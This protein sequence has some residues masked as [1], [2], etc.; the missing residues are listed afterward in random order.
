MKHSITWISLLATLVIGHAV[1]AASANGPSA[2]GESQAV[3]PE[4]TPA[5]P[6]E[7]END[8][9]AGYLD[10]AYVY[11]SAE[12]TALAARLKDYGRETHMSLDD[13]VT[14]RLEPAETEGD[15][16]DEVLVRR[17]AIARLLQYL[18]SG[19]ADALEASVTAV[20]TLEGR[21]GRHENRYW[22]YYILAHRA[23]E[24]GHRFDFV[25]DVLSLWLG[26][27][28][29]LETPYE[30]LDTL[31]L[32]EAPNSGFAAALPY[33]YENVARLVLIRSQE[34]GLD[35]DIDPLSSIVRLLA[36]GRVGGHPEV[37]PVAAS[38]KEY[39]ARIIERLNGPESD[40]GGL[41]FTLALFEATKL[42]DQ[43]RGLLASEGLGPKTIEAM[44]LASGAYQTALDRADTVQGQC[45]VYRRVL[46]LDK[47]AS[48]RDTFYS[49]V[50]DLIAAYECGF[51]DALV[52]AFKTKG[53][54]L[55]SWEV[56]ALFHRFEVQAH[57]KP[58][59]EKARNKMASRDLAFRD[60]LHLQLQEYVTPL[61]RD[62]FER[63]LGEKS[64]ELAERLEEAKDV[65]KRLKERQ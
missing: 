39:L 21:L 19:D 30:T 38:S 3:G 49:E 29:P 60:A 55:N 35:R 43:A 32:T 54:K 25:G 9:W 40:A 18:A 44:R 28:V 51:G 5:A 48:V 53:Q 15:D 37:I 34:M 31:S 22:Y 33:I 11:S 61:Q 65:M 57:W 24:K 6:A 47:R 1:H 16:A 41:T 14:R 64:K 59:I 62:E 46:R 26:V 7:V 63:F 12:P 20:R 58:L 45:A 42:H 27:V 36:D 23:L 50:L 56:D 2:G 8:A 10:F 52:Q 4:L 13:Y 17:L